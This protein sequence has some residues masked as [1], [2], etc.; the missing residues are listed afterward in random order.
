MNGTG[1]DG[2]L[3]SAGGD[4]IAGEQFAIYIEYGARV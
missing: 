2:I 1:P 4:D 3:I